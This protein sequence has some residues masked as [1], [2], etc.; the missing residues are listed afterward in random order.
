MPNFRYFSFYTTY[1]SSNINECF[2]FLSKSIFLY[3]L[4]CNAPEILWI[5]IVGGI[6]TG[7]P[8]A[9]A[10]YYFVVGAV[11]KY[12]KDLREKI[13]HPIKTAKTVHDQKLDRWGPRTPTHSTNAVPYD[14]RL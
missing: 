14:R 13:H 2:L 12:R 10:S 9:V 1:I 6:F 11:K 7:I 4:F 3:N 5:L 8:L